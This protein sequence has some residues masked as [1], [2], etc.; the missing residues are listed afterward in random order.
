MNLSSSST[1]DPNARR[2]ECG[3]VQRNGE[4]ESLG[5]LVL[6]YANDVRQLRSL[7]FAGRHP[8]RGFQ[9]RATRET[10]TRTTGNNQS[11]NERRAATASNAVANAR[12]V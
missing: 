9:L 11:K 4:D 6:R 3:A 5:C 8:R 10:G 1:A 12:T 2:L 7:Q